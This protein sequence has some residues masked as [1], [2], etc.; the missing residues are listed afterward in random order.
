MVLD[1][2]L[3]LEHH[4]RKAKQVDAIRHFY[5]YDYRWKHLQ[6]SSSVS[7]HCCDHGLASTTACLTNVCEHEHT[8]SCTEC[9]MWASLLD[10]ILV[11]LRQRGTGDS[12]AGEPS[13]DA[14]CA[15]LPATQL[16]VL[17]SHLELLDDEH[18]QYVAHLMRK[19][20]A[21]KATMTVANELGPGQALMW[22]DFKCKVL[23][24]EH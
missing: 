24:R 16:E 11:E 22:M 9:N 23:P 18:T 7:T 12:D 20:V 1:T 17:E 14:D 10:E 15:M 6:P 4:T 19:H 3:G 8:N 21:S 2:S 5:N 13:C